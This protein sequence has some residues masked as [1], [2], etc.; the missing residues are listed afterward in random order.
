[1]QDREGGAFNTF[2]SD[3]RIP[4]IRVYIYIIRRVRF[5]RFGYIYIYPKYIVS[6]CM[7]ILIR[8]E[9]RRGSNLFRFTRYME[10]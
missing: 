6:G 1:M 10:S 4:C 7:K 2:A 8:E 9:S 5:S 3:D